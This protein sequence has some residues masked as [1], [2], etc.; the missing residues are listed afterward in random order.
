MLR[1]VGLRTFCLSTGFATAFDTDGRVAVFAGTVPTDPE[2]AI[3]NTRLATLT[4]ASDAFGTPAT[5]AV[6][7]NAVTEDSSADATGTPTFAVFYKNGDTALTSAAS[8]SDRRM[9]V[10]VG[11]TGGGEE[12]LFSNLVGG[13]II[14]GTPVDITSFTYNETNP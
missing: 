6:S 1:S 11:A 13:Q 7:I 10:T 9:I 4:L 5:G 12:L 8:A 3:A 14:S 2:A